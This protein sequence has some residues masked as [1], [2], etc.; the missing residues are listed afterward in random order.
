MIFSSRGLEKVKQEY[1]EAHPSKS[2][3]IVYVDMSAVWLKPLY[4]REGDSTSQIIGT[5][6][7]HA[8]ITDF[9]GIPNWVKNKF[10]PIAINDT[11]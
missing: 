5:K 3:T 10:G 4:E 8:N 7:F 9:G 1:I 6:V 11:F 2:F